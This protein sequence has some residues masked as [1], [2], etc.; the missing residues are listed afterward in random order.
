MAYSFL[1]LSAMQF[2]QGTNRH[3]TY[4][5]T[6][7]DQ[8]SADNAVRLIIPPFPLALPIKPFLHLIVT[9]Q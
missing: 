2:I 9:I 8:V 6:P 7:D 3:Q 4:F 5:T 1:L